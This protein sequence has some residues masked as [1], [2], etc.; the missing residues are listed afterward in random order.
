MS[1][2]SQPIAQHLFRGNCE[3]LVEG[4][5]VFDLESSCECASSISACRLGI[6]NALYSPYVQ[7]CEFGQSLL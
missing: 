6:L 7:A 3:G 5:D 1:E 4:V 2:T